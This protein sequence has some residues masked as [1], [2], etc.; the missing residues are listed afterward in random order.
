MADFES[1]KRLTREQNMLTGE[2]TEWSEVDGNEQSTEQLLAIYETL[3]QTLAFE[4]GGT[5]IMTRERFERALAGIQALGPL[6]VPEIGL[7]RDVLIVRLVDPVTNK[8][9]GTPEV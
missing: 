2:A 3:V 7:S 9:F 6:V 1:G 5:F 8:S 4:S